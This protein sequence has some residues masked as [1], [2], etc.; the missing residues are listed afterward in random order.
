MNIFQ[1]FNELDE[2]I[3]HHFSDLDVA[4]KTERGQQ[5]FNLL[6]SEEN[7]PQLKE[8]YRH[9]MQLNSLAVEIKQKLEA[10]LQEEL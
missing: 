10:Q 1:L 9:H 2:V 8:W 5:L 3:A 4:L 7:R 6:L